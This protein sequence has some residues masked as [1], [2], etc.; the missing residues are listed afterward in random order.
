MSIITNFMGGS[1]DK[2]R[3]E[4]STATFCGI[5]QDAY[6][7]GR[8]DFRIAHCAACIETGRVRNADYWRNHFMSKKANSLTPDME[9]L[10]EKLADKRERKALLEG[11]GFNRSNETN[12]IRDI[13]SIHAEQAKFASNLETVRSQVMEHLPSVIA[14]LGLADKVDIELVADMIV[15]A[16]IASPIQDAFIA[17]S[18]LR[19]IV[20]EELI[21]K[22][23]DTNAMLSSEASVKPKSRGMKKVASDNTP[24]MYEGISRT[25]G[26]GYS[27]QFDRVANPLQNQMAPSAPVPP[28]KNSA[29]P[30]PIDAMNAPIGEAAPSPD[31]AMGMDPMEGQSEPEIVG[32]VTRVE[33]APEPQMMQDQMAQPQMMMNEGIQPVSPDGFEDQNPPLG[34]V[35][36]DGSMNRIQQSLAP[37]VRVVKAQPA[38]AKPAD[39]SLFTLAGRVAKNVPVQTINLD[40][41]A[42]LKLANAPIANYIIAKY[43][44]NTQKT[45]NYYAVDKGGIFSSAGV[46]FYA[47][48]PR[49]FAAFL[50]T[51]P[52]FSKFAFLPEELATQDEAPA[53]DL[54]HLGLP[55]EVAP[56]NQ[57]GA[58]TPSLNEIEPTVLNPSG[59]NAGLMNQQDDIFNLQEAH[60]GPD[61]TFGLDD[62]LG[63]VAA[64]A[65]PMAEESAPNA[66]PDEHINMAIAFA[67]TTLSGIRHI[68]ENHNH[69]KP[70]ETHEQYLSRLQSIYRDPTIQ[71]RWKS[72]YFNRGKDEPDMSLGEWLDAGGA[73]AQTGQSIKPEAPQEQG[74]DLVSQVPGEVGQGKP[75]ESNQAKENVTNLALTDHVNQNAPEIKPTN[76]LGTVPVGGVDVPADKLHRDQVMKARD[77]FNPTTV[78]PLTPKY[79]DLSNEEPAGLSKLKPHELETLND[80]PGAK[81][82][83]P[84]ANASQGATELLEVIA[85]MDEAIV[86]F[87]QLLPTFVEAGYSDDEIMEVVAILEKE[88]EGDMGVFSDYSAVTDVA[89]PGEADEDAKRGLHN[90]SDRGTAQSESMKRLESDSDKSNSNVQM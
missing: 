20:M 7:T 90:P 26:T 17:K 37:K 51:D 1:G 35:P 84:Y 24:V 36:M 32:A 59:E 69:P 2:P 39:M 74:Q 57:G 66:S 27:R 6:Q 85:S 83:L 76:P 42:K 65:L 41:T 46:E 40:A 63:D 54:S 25:N 70:N 9:V 73:K 53:T 44:D 77:T 87:A 86:D 52:R 3:K 18:A 68:A 14:E 16:K 4:A 88:A 50:A 28:D 33:E 29:I 15:P 81:K 12:S 19:S 75:W 67:A 79:Q 8:D 72:W 60:V 31:M 38:V 11:V 34:G 62:L 56:S 64:D 58:N 61:P 13:N 78:T 89:N 48:N 49:H 55:G 23:H 47:E 82:Y 10:L 71:K 80:P 45:W 43:H 5:C 21:G 22:F 30:A